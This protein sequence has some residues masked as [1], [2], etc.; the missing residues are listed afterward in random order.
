MLKYFVCLLSIL[1]L[2]GCAMQP[3]ATTPV[4]TYEINDLPNTH[5][6]SQRTNK[7]LLITTTTANPGFQSSQ[8]VYVKTPHQLQA[9]SKNRWVSPPADMINQT[10]VQSLES[11]GHYKAVIGQ[12]FTG[13]TDHRLNTHLVLLQHEHFKH[14]SQVRMVLDA[15]LIDNTSNHIIASKRFQATIAT[16]TDTPYSGIVAANQVNQRILSQLA[17]FCVKHS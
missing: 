12:P 4:A 6:Q 8:L 1:L 13:F 7:T 3:V 17:K 15:Q 9:Y 14:P 5:P 10:I 11:T 2:T 16:Q